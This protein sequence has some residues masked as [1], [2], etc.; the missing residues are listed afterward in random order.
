MNKPENYTLE[1]YGYASAVDLHISVEPDTDL[2]SRFKAYDHD[3]DEMIMVN[4]W[5]FTFD[6]VDA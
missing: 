2:D 1:L 6:Q 4:G 5:N 3:E